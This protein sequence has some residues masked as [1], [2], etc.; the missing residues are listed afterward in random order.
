MPKKTTVKEK[1]TV[2]KKVEKKKEVKLEKPVKKVV[3]KITKKADRTVNAAVKVTMPTPK[4]GISNVVA[5]IV[6]VS[7]LALAGF[8]SAK[9]A[10][11]ATTTNSNAGA[12][13]TVETQQ[14]FDYD[15]PEGQT[16]L[17]AL[18]DKATVQAQDSSYGVLVDSINDKANTDDQFWMFYVNGELSQIAP[19]QYNCKPGDKV[20]WRYEK[21]TF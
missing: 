20:E 15:C 19:D 12:T 2:T 16:A 13:P 9:Y 5:I 4:F 1:A 11:P 7:I 17:A 21:F 18:K 6:F 10:K 8:Y 14:T 3:K